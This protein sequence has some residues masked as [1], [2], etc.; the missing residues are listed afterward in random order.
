MVGG[1]KEVE[2]R[3]KGGGCEWVWEE[4]WTIGLVSEFWILGDRLA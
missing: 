2:R 4:R 1:G 3:R